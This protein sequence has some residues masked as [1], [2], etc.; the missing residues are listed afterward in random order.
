M[1]KPERGCGVPTIGSVQFLNAP[2]LCKRKQRR[3]A[4]H[5]AKLA[6]APHGLG[7]QG[8]LIPVG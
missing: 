6:R 1:S 5:A 3:A 2:P 8:G 7:R 4:L